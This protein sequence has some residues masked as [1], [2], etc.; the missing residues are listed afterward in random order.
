MPSVKRKP[1]AKARSDPGV[2]IVI[3]SGFVT[4][5]LPR[6]N[7]TMISSGSSTVRSSLA[8]RP[9]VRLPEY[10]SIETWATPSDEV[11]V[12]TAIS[13]DKRAEAWL[14]RRVGDSILAERYFG[15]A[16]LPNVDNRFAEHLAF[17]TDVMCC[18]IALAE[19]RPKHVPLRQVSNA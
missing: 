5:L 14:Q 6:R 8:M 15:E 10:F 3:E 2:R 18:A 16:R 11:D 13:E 4:R 17:P 1:T 19:P 12:G 7:F 9:E